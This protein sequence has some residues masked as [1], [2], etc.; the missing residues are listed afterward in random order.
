[1]ATDYLGGTLT[2][3]VGYE[4]SEGAYSFYI[5]GGPAIV[6]PNGADEELE[7]C[8]QVRWLCCCQPKKFLSMES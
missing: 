5:Q 2:M 7:L 3:D 8:W 4:V 6:M 1:M